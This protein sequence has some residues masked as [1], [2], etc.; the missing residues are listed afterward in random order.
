[1]HP[2]RDEWIEK[3]CK[4]SKNP[5]PRSP[6]RTEGIMSQINGR[7]EDREAQKNIKK[8]RPMRNSCK[9]KECYGYKSSRR[10]AVAEQSRTWQL[11]A[12]SSV[13]DIL[14]P[15]YVI[16]NGTEAQAMTWMGANTAVET[17]DKYDKIDVNKIDIKGAI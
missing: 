7:R 11:R 2:H 12:S 1:M 4:S 17:H 13:T 9:H 5:D 14:S 3:E 15:R 6:S 10:A 8:V 16:H